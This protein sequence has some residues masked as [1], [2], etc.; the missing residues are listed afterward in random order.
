[1]T[2]LKSLSKPLSLSQHFDAP[3]DFLGCFGWVCGYSADNGFLEDAVERFTRRTPAQRAHSGCVTMALMLDPSNA[4]IQPTEVPGVL[5]LPMKSVSRPFRLLHAKVALLGFRHVSDESQWQLRL[6]VSTGNWTR[7][8]LED[9]LD[10]A[11]RIDLCNSDLKVRDEE[12]R[13]A[14]A[15]I[16]AA[17][18]LLD[19]LRGLFDFRALI[20]K[21]EDRSD[22]ETMRSS[23]RVEAWIK[24]AAN[25]GR[26]NK[27]RFF[28][29]R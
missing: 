20:A 19:W 17:W 4:Q 1:M 26:A 14:R 23:Q 15:D 28:V 22:S 25:V 9:S 11:W 7:G 21:P 5:H 24:E 16:K 13:Q 2:N 12:V 8:T 29:T 27:P 6:I 18:N 10:L 3:D